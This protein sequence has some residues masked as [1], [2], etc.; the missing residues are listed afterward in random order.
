MPKR[1]QRGLRMITLQGAIKKSPILL[2]QYWKNEWLD[3]T[4]IISYF[5]GS[6]NIFADCTYTKG[7]YVMKKVSYIFLTH[8]LKQYY[9]LRMFK[10]QRLCIVSYLS[11]T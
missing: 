9:F 4:I 10:E 2:S 8:F 5:G 6:N 7:L 11:S 3:G 1:M